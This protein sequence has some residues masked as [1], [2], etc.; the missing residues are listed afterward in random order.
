MA[1]AQED[2]KGYDVYRDFPR[3]DNLAQRQH[4]PTCVLVTGVA[5]FIASHV[6]IRLVRLYPHYRVVGV[7]RLS[8]CSDIRNVMDPLA[9]CSNFRFVQADICDYERMVALMT[10]E[11]VDTVLHLAAQ[12]HVDLSFKQGGPRQFS[13]DNVEGTASLLEAAHKVG[14]RR[15][16]NCSTDEVYGEG[17]FDN[18][19]TFDEATAL[20]PTNPYSASKAGADLLAQSF[21]KSFGL[22]MVITRGNNVYGPHQFY[23][24]VIPKFIS[25]LWL[26]RRLTIHG[27]GGNTRNFLHVQDTASAFDAI[28]HCGL[29][30]E[31][32]N[33]GGRNE[34]SVLD[35][36]A[37]LLVLMGLDSRKHELLE[38]VPDRLHNDACYPISCQ[39]LGA[40]G[41]T[42]QLGWEFGLANT[43][44]FFLQRLRSESRDLSE[45]VQATRSIQ[46]PLHARASESPGGRGLRS[47]GAA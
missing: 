13:R 29:D 27:S 33:I 2:V 17:S 22:P 15:F 23:E 16:V 1:K 28:M 10:E 35:V 31:A 39:K 18:R 32:Y 25:Q 7:D 38:H 6:T 47:L 43:T 8:Y 4:T 26:G 11:K 14:I 5:G 24:K 41:W 34:K 3:L 46:P 36:A 42:E 21:H 19:V 12:S 30:G 45:L 40:L 37:D 44:A 9:G 20:R